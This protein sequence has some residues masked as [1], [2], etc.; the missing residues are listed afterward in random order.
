MHIQHA[1]GRITTTITDGIA[2]V[3]LTRPDKMNALD[4]AMFEALIDT[5]DSLARNPDVRVI[6]LSGEGRAFCAGLDMGNFA[7][8]A[9]PSTP[10]S[11]PDA[12]ATPRPR[13]TLGPR[14]HG[15][16]NRAQH[17]VWTWRLCPVPVIAA[18]HGVCLGGGLQVAL[19]ADIRIAHPDTKLSIM[20]LKWGLIP[21]MGGTPM[22]RELLREDVL[23]ELTYTARTL[24]AAEAQPLGLVTRLA[25]DPHAE[26][27]ALAHEITSKSPDAIRAAKTLL[28]ALPDSTEAQALQRESDLQDTLIARPNQV[29]AVM[30]T[31]EKRPPRY[32][33]AR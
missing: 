19:G 5:G 22:L 9:A 31:L 14:T 18:L 10:P 32:A 20:E 12:G 7:R 4:D 1:S 16:A 21:D 3:R 27:L 11:T 29:E 6:I 33:N 23:R 26:A 13:S 15:I 2:D 28:N 17:A 30:S 8:M 25:D 24:T